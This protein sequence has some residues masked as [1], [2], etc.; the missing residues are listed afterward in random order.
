MSQPNLQFTTFYLGNDLFGID[1]MRVQEITQKTTV[2]K[3][4][5]A[6]GF[7]RG[8]INLRG[9]IATALGLRQLFEL[10]P[11]SE[12]DQMS[13][14]CKV[15]GNLVSLLVD[16]IGDVLEVQ[17][18]NYEHAPETV[19]TSVRKYLKGVYKIEGNL[20]SI[21]DLDCLSKELSNSVDLTELNKSKGV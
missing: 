21:L 16:S 3:V 11:A 13:V 1:V 4:P 18:D 14:V 9:Q 19:R 7:V 6:P 10:E 15:D 20:L 17:E 5:L 8:L 12:A 2:V